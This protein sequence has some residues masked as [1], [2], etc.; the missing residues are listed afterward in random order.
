[1]KKT[2]ITILLILSCLSLSA[3]SFQGFFDIP[4]NSDKNFVHKTM[5]DIGFKVDDFMENE[6]LDHT[7]SIYFYINNSSYT[8][9]DFKT[10]IIVF[11]FTDN[12]LDYYTFYGEGMSIDDFVSS[13]LKEYSTLKE[14]LVRD[15]Y[16]NIDV[17]ELKDIYSK[18]KIKIPLHGSRYS[19][20]GEYNITVEKLR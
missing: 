11:N 9:Y 7:S 13:L 3:K 10:R 4:L 14:D 2:F 8:F 17:I 15:D 1:M 20:I 18:V 12:K 6:I 19:N 16:Y 5:K